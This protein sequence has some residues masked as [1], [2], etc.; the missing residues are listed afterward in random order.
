MAIL[1]YDNEMELVESLFATYQIYVLKHPETEKIFYVGQ[2]TKELKM[3]MTGHMSDVNGC[4]DRIGSAKVEF[5]KKIIQ[6]GGKPIIEAIETI[7]GTCYIDKALAIERE[8]YWMKY[9]TDAGEPITNTSGMQ[10]DGTH[11]LY[12]GYLA[13]LKRGETHWHYYICGRTRK[14]EDVYDRDRL[15]SD[16]FVFPNQRPVRETL[17]NPMENVLFLAK[18]G[19]LKRKERVEIKTEVFPAQPQWTNEFKAGLVFDDLFDET[20]DWDDPDLELE[21]DYEPESDYEPEETDN[22]FIMEESFAQD[23]EASYRTPKTTDGCIV[24]LYPIEI[25]REKYNHL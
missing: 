2:T 24:S 19:L 17:Y 1:A 5:I 16:G 10:T 15:I 6:E 12:Q 18:M 14:G 22:D 7:R 23:H 11:R 25:N 20:E 3:R 13:S 8:L 21:E 9:Y 4:K